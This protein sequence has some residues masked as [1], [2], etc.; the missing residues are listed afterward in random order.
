MRVA[1][2][3]V[4]PALWLS[5]PGEPYGKNAVLILFPEHVTVR[6]H[7]SKQ[8]EHLYLWRSGN[9][10]TLPNW[11]RTANALKYEMEL[12]RGVHF[13]ARALL[14]NDGVLLHY[15]FVNASDTDYDSFQAIT[16]PRMLTPL[17]HDVRLERTYFH[18]PNGF[19]LLASDVPDRLTMPLD[20]WLPNR[21]RVSYAWPVDANP[22]EKQADGIVFF[23]ASQR[24]DEPLLATV[25]TDNHWIMATFSRA[26]GNLWTNPELTCQHADPD[27]TVSPRSTG[28]LEEKVLLM[29]GTLED[30]LAQAREQRANLK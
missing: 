16:D 10:G 9:A 27:I 5:I 3:H 8:A 15:E 7:G 12:D 11:T 30:V 28:V 23:N 14:E 13:I 18:S 6:R 22:I 25:S 2:E 20:R 17:L 4:S 29:T 19:R 26:P 1:E 24:A 21:Y